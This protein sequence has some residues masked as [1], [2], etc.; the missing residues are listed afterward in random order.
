MRHEDYPCCGCGPE[1]CVDT[2][3]TVECDGCGRDYHP[4]QWTEYFCYRCQAPREASYSWDE[5]P[6]YDD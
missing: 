2:S 5:D 4:D 3:R 1:G 6:A